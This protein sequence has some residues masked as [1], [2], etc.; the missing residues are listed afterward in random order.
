MICPHRSE[1]IG[2][3]KQRYSTDMTQQERSQTRMRKTSCWVKLFTSIAIS[4][5]DDIMQ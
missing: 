2:K 3:L 1:Y 5:G 4:Y